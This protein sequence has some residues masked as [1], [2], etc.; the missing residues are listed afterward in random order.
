VIKQRNLNRL[1]IQVLSV[2]DKSPRQKYKLKATCKHIIQTVTH[3]AIHGQLS[4]KQVT[5]VK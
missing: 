3:L 5:E 2:Q 1:T 4:N